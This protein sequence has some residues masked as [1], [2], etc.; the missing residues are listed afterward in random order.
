MIIVFF[1][2]TFK[3]LLSLFLP[4]YIYCFTGCQY[5]R[6]AESSSNISVSTAA[7]Q[8][9]QHCSWLLSVKYGNI[10][11]TF[12]SMSVPDCSNDNFIEIFDGPNDQS[13]SL[14]KYCGRPTPI[15]S[16]TSTG[17]HLF[18]LVKSGNNKQMG[19]TVSFFATY[20][21]TLTFMPLYQ[22]IS[23]PT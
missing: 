4:F 9:F 11:L 14:A 20:K 23:E 12:N 19:T 8:D 2:C 22:L 1:T 7:N 17:K 5:K 13:V 6:N 3:L 15:G 10:T 16:I 18:I 21:S